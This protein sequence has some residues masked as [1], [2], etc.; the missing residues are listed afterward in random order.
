[1]AKIRGAKEL[2][3]A[4]KH[5]PSA[6]RKEATEE[7]KISSQTMYR[8]VMAG[9]ATAGRLAPLWHGKIGMQRITGNARRFYRHSVSEKKM[10][11]RVGLLTPGAHRSAFYL[12]MFFYGT[13]RQPARNIH[14]EV[15]EDEADGF[16]KAQQKALDRVVRKL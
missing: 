15:F 12:R 1:M 8:R 4:L 3:R 10:S 2:R 6:L 5:A 7:V 13:Y 16:V 11:G 9:L 14:E